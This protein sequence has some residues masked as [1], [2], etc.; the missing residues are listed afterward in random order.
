MAGLLT[1]G[2]LRSRTFPG[3][4]AQWSS[5][6]RSPPTVAGAVTELTHARA[7]RTVFP[8]NLFGIVPLRTIEGDLA[9]LARF[10]QE[11]SFL[12]RGF[13]LEQTKLVAETP[14]T[15]QADVVSCDTRVK[16]DGPL[17]VLVLV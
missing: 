6:G 1:C 17:A 8:F 15:H 16:L 2:S 10:G 11:A 9:A 5:R 7:R 14:E 3:C 12:Q 13:L 4:L